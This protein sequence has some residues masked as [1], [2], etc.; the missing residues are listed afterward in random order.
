MWYQHD[1]RK[2][3]ELH[4]SPISSKG[5]D[6]EGVF[7]G[8][9]VELNVAAE[10]PAEAALG[11]DEGV[12]RSRVGEGSV[13]DPSCIDEVRCC[14]MSGVERHMGLSTWEDP[15]RDVVWCR[16]PLCVS[17]GGGKTPMVVS[18]ILRDIGMSPMADILRRG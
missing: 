15:I 3:N 13:W 2:G 1:R 6:E 12:L 17:G 18:G 14:A 8:L 16:V 7:L 5:R 10:V 4:P 11:D 9:L